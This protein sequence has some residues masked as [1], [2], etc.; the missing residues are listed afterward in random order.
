M[1]LDT[2]PLVLC[3]TNHVA[4]NFNANALLAIGASPIMSFDKR[5]TEE[6]V[7]KCNALYINIGCIDPSQQEIM[8]IAAK[9]ACKYGKPWVLD[10]VGAGATRLRTE[11]SGMLIR[12]YHPSVIRGNAAE[13]MALEGFESRVRGVDSK[14]SPEIAKEAALELSRHTGAVVSV[15][16]EI[17]LITDSK[18][19]KRIEGGSDIMPKV[20]GMGCTA[21]ALTAALLSE[22]PSHL[23]AA[24][25]AMYIMAVSGERSGKLSKGTGTFQ[26]HFLDC[27]SNFD[28]TDFPCRIWTEKI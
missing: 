9:A 26:M 20:T 13:I 3:L 22:Y 1:I 24:V 6:L 18:L 2:S 10:P 8:E 25:Q 16:G 4:I 21:S 15:S 19:I 17:D 5:E 28:P 7:E 11:V 12:D 23:D 27:L 14:E